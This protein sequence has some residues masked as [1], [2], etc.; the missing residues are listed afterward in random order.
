MNKINLSLV[1]KIP[2]KKNSKRI[3]RGK[4]GQP[5]ITGSAEYNE[6]QGLA[7]DHFIWLRKIEER[8]NERKFPI[9]AGNIKAIKIK[10]T[11]GDKRRRDLTNQAESIMDALVDAGIITDDSYQVVPALAMSGRFGKEFRCE[12]EIVLK[13]NE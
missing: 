7:K 2:S 5:F 12:I 13:G 1:E 11:F 9:E 3:F 10:F 6:W 4:N 8:S